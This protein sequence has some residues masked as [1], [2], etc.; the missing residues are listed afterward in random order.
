MMLIEPPAPNVAPAA[1]DPVVRVPEVNATVPSL[2][3]HME[4]Q[5]PPVTVV[6][7]EPVRE[8]AV[9]PLMAVTIPRLLA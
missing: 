5:T 7:I 6:K 8:M 9:P 4:G 3:V 1:S 2:P